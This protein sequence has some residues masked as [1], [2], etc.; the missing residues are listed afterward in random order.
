M[1]PNRAHY[2]NTISAFIRDRADAICGA[3]ASRSAFSIER[4]QL[5]AWREQI[6]LLQPV[7]V[8]YA[9]QGHVFFEFVLPRIGRR[10]DVILVIKHV[11]LVLE[12]KVGESAFHRHAIDQVWDYALDLKNF[13]EPSH[14]APIVPILI[15]TRAEAA[16]IQIRPPA[17]DGVYAPL[18]VV[19]SRLGHVIETVLRSVG[20]E[21]INGAAWEAGRYSPTPTIIE[22]ARALYGGHSVAEISRSDAGA[23]NLTRTSAY[24]S[25]IIAN[26]QRD[27]RKV[28]CLLT[29]VPGAGKTLVG[30]DIAT[31]HMDAASMLYS[32]FLSGNGP[33]VSILREALA[34]GKVRTTRGF[35][36][37]G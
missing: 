3:L 18:M 35:L 7:L 11:V 24:V 31:Q 10:V 9:D 23:S 19:P 32:V 5:Q 27:K 33:L 20:G 30:L 21:P 28:V 26:A 14:R 17:A 15:P 13:H 37:E 25:E 4:P 22:A 34:L 2:Q 6:E 12:F 36:V 8:P 16:E 29:G 1:T